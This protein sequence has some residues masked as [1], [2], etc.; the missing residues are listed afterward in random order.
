MKTIVTWFNQKG[1]IVLLQ[2]NDF[3]EAYDP[4]DQ[5]RMFWP[6]RVLAVHPNSCSATI[7][8]DTFASQATMSLRRLYPLLTHMI[9]SLEREW[10]KR[11]RND[12][13]SFYQWTNT[14]VTDPADWLNRWPLYLELEVNE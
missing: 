3:V 14:G 13:A 2:R 1:S 5:K 10:L 4:A 7:Q 9:P 8:Y 6:A 12:F 11:R